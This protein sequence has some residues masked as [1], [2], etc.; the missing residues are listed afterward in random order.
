MKYTKRH[1]EAVEDRLCDYIHAIESGTG[2]MPDCVVC[3]T[4]R[5]KE[6]FQNCSNCCLENCFDWIP[7]LEIKESNPDIN[8]YYENDLMRLGYRAEWVWLRAGQNTRKTKQLA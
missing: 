3:T 8:Y 1:I 4:T 6:R 5:D 2:Y 7:K